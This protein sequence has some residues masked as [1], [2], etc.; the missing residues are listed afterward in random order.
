MSTGLFNMNTSRNIEKK[1]KMPN[2][3]V[4]IKD[5]NCYIK[6]NGIENMEKNRYAPNNANIA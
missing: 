4:D 5:I 2:F 3:L 1:M 6:N